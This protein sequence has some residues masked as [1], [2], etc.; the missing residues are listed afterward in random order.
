MFVIFRQPL[1]D[2]RAFVPPETR[3]RPMLTWEDPW[4]RK[5]AGKKQEWVPL[6]GAILGAGDEKAYCEARKLVRFE[7][8]LGSYVFS[9]GQQQLTGFRGQ[10]RKASRRY[11]PPQA[12]SSLEVRLQR[13]EDGTILSGLDVEDFVQAVLG[14]RVK[15]G[16]PAE[17]VPLAECGRHV[18]DML[19]LATTRR[20]QQKPQPL[21]HRLLRRASPPVQQPE[22]WWLSPGR[23]ML[24]LTAHSGGFAQLEEVAD[25][26]TGTRPG[27]RLHYRA[28]SFKGRAIPVW[29][30][31]C[32]RRHGSGWVQ[33]SISETHDARELRLLLQRRHSE[34]ECAQWVC[35]H[36]EDGRLPV[37]HG[38]SYSTELQKYAKSAHSLLTKDRKYGMRQEALQVVADEA[39]Y[40]VYRDDIP[41][42]V[43]RLE[44]LLQHLDHPTG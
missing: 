43:E 8:P 20:P 44:A 15:A 17:T 42:L 24:L 2:V 25:E 41:R 13:P 39:M 28:H 40:R 11:C 38:S 4:R 33:G 10:K 12:L 18:A 37:V 21:L 16:S 35:A 22:S 5:D 32:T 34:I 23:P 29:L 14:V 31:E 26:V 30:I 1:S 7:D 3:M 9:A 6:V 36:Y 19:L 27:V